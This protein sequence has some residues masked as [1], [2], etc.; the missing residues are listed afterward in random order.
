MPYPGALT[1]ADA[2]ILR[3]KNFTPS[4]AWAHRGGRSAPEDSTESWA[5][6]VAAGFLA[7]GD[8]RQSSDG[9]QFLMHDATVDRTVPPN[10]GAI[11]TFTA[12]ALDAMRYS[13]Y[14]G[15]GFVN[16][17]V[18]RFTPA[19][20]AVMAQNGWAA[21]E[22][23]IQTLAGMNALI[24][25]AE[26]VGWAHRCIFQMFEAAP[27]TV[28]SQCTFNKPGYNFLVAFN[29]GSGQP[30]FATIAAAGIR[31]VGMDISDAWVTKAI[32]D[33]GHALGL[34]FVPYVVDSV[35]QLAI[36]QAAGA[37]HV[38]TNR[39]RFI[40]KGGPSAGATFN[41]S[42]TTDSKWMFA[43]D[44]FIDGAAVPS[45][46]SPR[47]FNG[48]AGMPTTTLGTPVGAVCEGRPLPAGGTY[49]LDFNVT[50]RVAN[51]DTT[52]WA[53]IQLALQ[54]T[55]L[56]RNFA[57][58]DVGDNGYGFVIRQNG[59]FYIDRYTAGVN[60]VVIAGPSA[61]PALVTNTTYPFRIIVSPTTLTFK[62]VDT[63]TTLTIADATWRGGLLGLVWS[64]SGMYFGPIV[65]T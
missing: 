5:D 8:I 39:P 58:V 21:P 16:S 15:V 10:S 54:S 38:F 36:A 62:R 60:S 37:D 18:S 12:A 31:Y 55:S 17:P 50:V 34:K 57:P 40:S 4:Y 1:P 45:V 51:A 49:Q 6:A 52:R 42:W 32:F 2:A 61:D 65:G 13:Q 22:A 9:V 63:G 48:E 56:V 44:W 30:N 23:E 33:S 29:T 35:A 14:N 25:E 41:E 46:N 28:L 3:R 53:G 11:N 24:A 47:P 26:A 19:L 43:D 27:Y 20:Q 7:E 64:S 59:A